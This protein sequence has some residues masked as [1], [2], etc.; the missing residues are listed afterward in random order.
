VWGGP[1]CVIIPTDGNT[2]Y[3]TFWAVPSS[4]DPDS[5]YRYQ[6]TGVDQRT[7][8]YVWDSKEPG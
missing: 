8:V 6:R 2:I 7:E 5:I 1:H 3:E 4:H